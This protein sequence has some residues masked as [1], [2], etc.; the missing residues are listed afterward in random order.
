[1][2]FGQFIAE[3]RKR[4]RLSQ[5]ELAARIKKEDS[6]PI[7]P[8]YLNAVEHNRRNPPSEFIM[9]QLASVLQVQL[10]ILYS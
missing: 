3:A 5:K 7:S 8:Q 10:D 9:K 2:T 4:A 6:Q 1:M